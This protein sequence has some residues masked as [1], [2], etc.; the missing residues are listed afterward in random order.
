MF[1]IPAAGVKVGDEFTDDHGETWYRV[2][3]M[4]YDMRRGVY[5]FECE[6]FGCK[7]L[8]ETRLVVVR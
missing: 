6:G 2:V 5:S 7:L 4:I 3:S 1:E 8:S